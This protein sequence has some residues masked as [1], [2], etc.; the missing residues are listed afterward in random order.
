[1]KTYQFFRCTYQH[2]QKKRKTLIYWVRTNNKL[3][4]ELL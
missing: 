2:S 1:M 4:I 3:C